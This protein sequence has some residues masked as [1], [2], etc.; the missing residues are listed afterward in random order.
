M[1][2]LTVNVSQAKI[3]TG[4]A[5]RESLVVESQQ[6]QDRGMQVVQMNFVL[7]RVIA[8]FVGGA[9]AKPS[10]YASA[11]EEHRVAL[12]VMVSAV[13]ALG[14]RRASKFATPDNERVLKQSAAFQVVQQSSNWLIDLQGIGGVLPF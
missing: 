14:G 13:A 7:H 8:V 11:G 2:H 9:V 1:D 6:M 4:K 5:K 12:R 3:A 10:L